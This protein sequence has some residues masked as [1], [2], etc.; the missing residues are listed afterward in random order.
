MPPERITLYDQ[1]VTRLKRLT[2]ADSVPVIGPADLQDILNQFQRARLWEASTAYSVGDVIQPNT[3]NGFR[4][5]CVIA[6][7]SDTT[8]PDFGTWRESQTSDGDDLVWE[9]AGAEYY[10][11]W[12]L[13]RAAW[14]VMN[15]KMGKALC[16]IDVK[17]SDISKSSSQIFDHLKTIRDSFVTAEVG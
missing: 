3:P 9:E 8:E 4:Y 14:E 6:G 13:T 17:T 1:A 2:D 10:C 5:V 11:L 16:A 7:T 12:D 15:W